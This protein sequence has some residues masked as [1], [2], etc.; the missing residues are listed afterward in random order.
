MTLKGFIVDCDYLKFRGRVCIVLYLRTAEG[1]PAVVFDP[2]YR[3][4]FYILPSDI[5]KAEVE[6]QELLKK[7]KARVE[8]I[9]RVKLIHEGL[10]K[11]F[12]KVTCLLPQDTQ[13]VRDIVKALEARRGGSGSVIDEFEYQIGF[14]RAY[15]MDRGLNGVSPV[16]VEAELVSEK[17]RVGGLPTY[18]AKEIRPLNWQ[19]PELQILAFDTEVVEPKR[20]ERSLIMLSLYGK[21]LQKVLTYKE[22]EYP[23]YVEVVKDE[24]TLIEKFVEIVNEYDP[25]IICGYNSDLYDFEVLRERAQK[26]KT[27]LARLSR[28]YSGVTMSKRARFST[29]RLKGRVHIDIFNFINNI[30]APILQTEVLSLDAVSAEI[31]GDEKIEMQYH[32][33]VEAWQREKQL[34]KLAMYCLKDSELTYRLTEVLMPQILEHTVIVG[35]ALYDVS[36]MT[37]SQLVEWFYSKKAKQTGRVI[38]NQP[39]FEEIKARQR[40]TYIGGYVKEPEVGLHENIAVVDF[41]SLYPSIIATYNISTETLDCDCCQKDGHRVPGLDHWFCRRS[42]GFESTVIRELLEERQ[43][44]KEQMKTLPKDSPERYLLDTRQKAVKTIANASYGYFGFAAS[45]WYCKACAESITAFGRYWIQEVMARAEQAGFRPIYGDTDS[46]FLLVGDRP[47]EE[48]LEFLDE[49]NTRLPGLMRIELEDFY[50]RGIFIPK[51]IGGGTA[52]KRYA[53]VDEEGNL[54]VRGLEKVRRDWSQIARLTQ[55]ALLKKVLYEADIDGAVQVVKDAIERLRSGSF[56]IHD[57]VVYEQLSKPLSEYKHTTAHVEA[58]KRL[59]EKGVELQPGS[60]VGY[61]ITRGTAS[62]SKRAMPVEFVSE[63]D[64][65]VEYY[66]QNQILPASMR[67]LKTVGVQEDRLSSQDSLF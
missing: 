6:V 17:E 29:A 9:E 25:D 62:I 50:L 48:L 7:K 8:A 57:V 26:L 55:E 42:Q 2:S 10:E 36:R 12:L 31:L 53:L 28:D 43:A 11:E 46:A 66:I 22:A 30:F 61:V 14:Y 37:Y 5:Q 63:A 4:Y 15:L 24:K 35:Q 23:E 19:S 39:K 59:A 41:A 52:K 65:D 45:K 54:K 13:K 21:D 60:V 56:D 32:E 18:E 44:L 64:V 16:E 67:I 33:I 40:E 20:G 27:P 3:P 34:P 58:A 47:K 49:M 1:A 38:P 51:E